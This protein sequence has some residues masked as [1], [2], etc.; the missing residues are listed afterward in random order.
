MRKSTDLSFCYWDDAYKHK[1]RHGFKKFKC[2]FCHFHSDDQSHLK[3]HEETVHENELFTCDQC[4]Y[5]TPRKDNLL[6]HTRSNHVEKN[7]KCELCEYVTHRIE[8]MKRH[9]QAGAELCQT[10][11]QFGLAWFGLHHLICLHT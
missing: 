5:T 11:G 6:R 8:N 10:Q 9:K 2:N 4:E 7:I 1:N 3:R